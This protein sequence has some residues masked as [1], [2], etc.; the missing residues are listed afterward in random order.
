MDRGARKRNVRTSS[1]VVQIANSPAS[2]PQLD[3]RNFID[4]KA[5][6]FDHLS[7]LPSPIAPGSVFAFVL[8]SSYHGVNATTAIE[9]SASTT[10]MAPTITERAAFLARLY[11]GVTVPLL[12][13]A[14]VPFCAR[15]YV[16]IWPVWRLGWDDAFII[17]GVAC[18]IIDWGLLIPEMHIHPGD[19]SM[20]EV[21]EAVFVAYF[22][23]PIWAISMTL[24]K[25]SIVLTLLRLP[26]KKPWRIGLYVIAA[27][28]VTYCVADMQYLFF[29]CRPF[30][31]AWDIMV[32]LR[33][34]KCPSL[35]TDIVVSSIGSAINITTDLL[36]SVAP[37][38]ILWNLRRPLRERVVICIL[39]GMGLFASVA[40]IMKAVVV[41]DW[42]NVDDQWEMA[43][44]IATWTILEQL[45]S[46]FAACCPSLKG[47][48]QALLSKCGVSLT[49]QNTN[50]SFVHIPSRMRENQLRREAREWLGEEDLQP[51]RQGPSEL[52]AVVDEE[53]ERS[54]NNSSLVLPPLPGSKTLI[55]QFLLRRQKHGA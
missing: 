42:R 12:A 36:L 10:S 17:A 7:H 54:K 23:I 37:M 32:P 55:P 35:H 44:S 25:T 28:Q 4:Q 20:D 9:S 19:I 16:R 13:L 38:F 26:L 3:W 33:E 52:I 51:S 29:K 11:F 34:R 46:L 22:A 45:I 6:L 47:P 27:V 39:T 30:H 24:I 21:R 43:M 49:R 18:S 14:L 1:P 8:I 48:I 40:S 31:A 5:R 53:S 15:I 41:A 2:G 50:V